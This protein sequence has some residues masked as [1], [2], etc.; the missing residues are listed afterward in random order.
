MRIEREAQAPSFII[1]DS[2]VNSA[3]ERYK[4][5][6][7]Q[8]FANQALQEMERERDHRALY[9]FII[10]ASEARRPSYKLGVA[11]VYTAITFQFNQDKNAFKV[12]SDDLAVYSRN[13]IELADHSRWTWTWKNLFR[14]GE[15]REWW[16]PLGMSSWVSDKL[17][18]TSP[19]LLKHLGGVAR[20]EDGVSTNDFWRGVQDGSMPIICRVES[21][22]LAKKLFGNS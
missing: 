10:D 2:A 14:F 3:I 8:E 22:Q 6:G 1:N 16:R 17:I 5:L 11:L 4:E 13:L 20:F 19:R 15:L 7:G 21:A 9:R 18:Q 12:S